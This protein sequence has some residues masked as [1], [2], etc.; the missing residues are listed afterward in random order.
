MEKPMMQ[1]CLFG[2]EKSIVSPKSSKSFFSE[3]DKKNCLRTLLYHSSW[4][5]NSNSNYTIINCIS[6]C[7]L[8]SDLKLVLNETTSKNRPA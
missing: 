2:L 1:N 5:N 6:K 7:Q 4:T 8:K 3:I